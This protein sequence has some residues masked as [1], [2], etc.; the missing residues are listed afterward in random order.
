M[1]QPEQIIDFIENQI[2]TSH[3]D[4]FYQKL[5][6]INEIQKLPPANDTYKFYFNQEKFASWTD[7]YIDTKKMDFKSALTNIWISQYKI[8]I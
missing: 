6:K 4:K 1:G 5:H 3:L 8:E 7:A 2:D